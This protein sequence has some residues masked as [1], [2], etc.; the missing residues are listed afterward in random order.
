[1]AG[2]DNILGS[3]ANAT[4]AMLG[5]QSSAYR[6]MFALQQSFAIG[7][8]IV[9]IHKAISDAFAEG[10]TLAQKF[11]GVATATTQGMKIVSA[12]QQIRNPVIGQ[13]HDGIMSVPKSGTWNLEKGERVLPKH[14]AKALDDRL[15]NMGG[16]QVIN[17]HVTVNSDGSNVQAD[18]QMG[19][20]MGEAMAKIARQVMIQETKQNGHLD[21]LYRR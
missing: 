14:T 10:T 17:V 6:A 5:E 9:N 15:D 16:G 21:R 11:A 8:A 12:I 4:K 18:T 3:M 7:T 2:A 13:A 1:M 20:N 19:K